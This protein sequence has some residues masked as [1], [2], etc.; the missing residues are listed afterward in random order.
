[1]R[2]MTPTLLICVAA[3]AAGVAGTIFDLGGNDAPVGVYGGTPTISISNFVFSSLVATPGASVTVT[4]RDDSP[5]TV[6]AETKAFTSGRVDG[7][8]SGTFVA[9]STP[10]Q[11]AIY[12]EIHASMRGTLVVSTP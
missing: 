2:W 8:A 9:P 11:Y 10:G 3:F 12:C 5:H 1:M 4:N 7:K 6:T